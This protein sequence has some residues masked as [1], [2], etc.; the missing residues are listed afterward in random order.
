MML[1]DIVFIILLTLIPTL[2]L[3]A[4]IPY[5]FFGTSLHWGVVFL[6]AVV[7]NILLAPL[8]YLFVDKIVHLFF[9]IRWLHDLYYWT[10]EYMQK[11]A[12]PY[13]EKY[14]ELGLAM[15]IGVPIP[16]SGVYSGVLAAYFLDFDYRT[17]MMASVKGVL[18]A[19]VLVMLICLS[20][21]HT[22]DFF[23]KMV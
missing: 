3:R 12:H 13:V 7:V 1:Y 20:G 4:S 16:G 2:E 17:I 23:I 11:K 8:V 15:F 5:G 6:I 19:G 14:G 10:A 21:D 22:F 18:I 9:R